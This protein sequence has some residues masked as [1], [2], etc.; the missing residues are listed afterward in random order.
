[1]LKLKIEKQSKKY[2]NTPIHLKINDPSI[3][4]SGD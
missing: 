2:W 3:N 1:M 4:I